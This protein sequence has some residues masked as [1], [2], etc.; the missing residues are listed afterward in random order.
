MS[1]E[2]EKKKVERLLQLYLGERSELIANY[3][4]TTK[5]SSYFS[6]F[7][8]PN[9]V[10]NMRLS[11]HPSIRKHEKYLKVDVSDKNLYKRLKNVTTTAPVIHVSYQ[12][13]ATLKFLQ[14]LNKQHIFLRVEKFLP[15]SVF[16]R[17]VF[18]NQTYVDIIL[19]HALSSSLIDLLEYGLAT[20]NAHLGDSNIYI[21]GIGRAVVHRL[22]KKYEK[23]W[24][25]DK[26]EVNLGYLSLPEK[27]YERS[28]TLSLLENS[29]REEWGALQRKSKYHWYNSVYIKQK[30]IILKEDVT[31]Y[32][33]RF[34]LF[35]QKN[36][37]EN[38][39]YKELTKIHKKK[40]DAYSMKENVKKEKQYVK[41]QMETVINGRNKSKIQDLVDN[42]LFEK[43]QQ[44]KQILPEE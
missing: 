30:F 9:T 14:M 4:S 43:L 17:K 6:I 36:K 19:P 11:N 26:I 1:I 8:E 20:T 35:F 5:D 41:R 21:T 37:C 7:L 23:Y 44:F 22:Q 40:T 2:R 13:Y 29:Q 38:Q 32:V 42:D 33:N 3:L 39:T 27:I 15:L 18:I 24:R 10:C 12:H 31:H 28:Q 16:A 25:K 34:L